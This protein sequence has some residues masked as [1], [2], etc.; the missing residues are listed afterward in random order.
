MITKYPTSIPSRTQYNIN[1]ESDIPRDIIPVVV[2]QDADLSL[3]EI[4]L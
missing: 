1:H 2:A 4:P 3:V